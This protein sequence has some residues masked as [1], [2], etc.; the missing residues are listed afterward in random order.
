M[1]YLQVGLAFAVLS[2]FAC[3]RNQPIPEAVLSE[4]MKVSAITPSGKLIIEC[5]NGTTRTYQGENWSKASKLIPRTTRWS[6]SLGLYDPAG[7]N[8]LGDRLLLEEGRQFFS[9]ESEAM[10]YLQTLNGYYGSVTYS[11]DGL[12]VT[13]SVTAIP[14]EKPTR[15][16]QLWQIYINGVKPKALRGGTNQ[17]I[18]IEGGTILEQATPT[19]APVGYERQISD[20]EYA[21]S[22]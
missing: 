1:R 10:R 8:T 4:G 9:S 16:I 19:P 20:K 15:D 6:G 11:N 7:S 5:G 14:N 12:V 18:K 17:N 3:N 21:P 22:R 2:A 13:Y